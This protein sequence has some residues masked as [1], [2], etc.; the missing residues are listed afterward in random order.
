[1]SST[2][3]L[4]AMWAI[5]K[6]PLMSLEQFLSIC[7]AV[8]VILAVSAVGFMVRLLFVRS[9]TLNLRREGYVSIKY[10]SS[11]IRVADWI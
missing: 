5:E 6:E 4:T 3:F 8:G 7:K 2:M 1:M 9:K 10:S 11:E